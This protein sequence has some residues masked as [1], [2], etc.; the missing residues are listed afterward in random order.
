M[1]SDLRVKAAKAIGTSFVVFLLFT[2]S[3]YFFSFP[4]VINTS[5][6]ETQRTI[7]KLT[8]LKATYDMTD[9]NVNSAIAV[10]P[11]N[12]STPVDYAGGNIY[13]KMTVTSKPTD[14]VVVDQMCLYSS[15]FT[16]TTCSSPPNDPY[17]TT[18]TFYRKLPSMSTWWSAGGFDI[19]Q[20][21]DVIKLV[22][23]DASW[24]PYWYEQCGTQRYTGPLD[25]HQHM[26]YFYD[27]EAIMVASGA[28]LT[29]P[30]DWAD[31]PTTICGPGG[32]LPTVN[33][34]TV[35]T[36]PPSGTCPLKSTGDADCTG[37]TTVIDYTLWRLEYRAGCSITNQTPATCFDDR[38]GDG[39]LID[40]DFNGDGKASLLDFPRWKRG[41]AGQ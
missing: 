38:D 20:P 34:T 17:S 3:I 13:Y 22:H 7:F 29:R 12:W 2:A 18:G 11:A 31:C 19:N 5:A 24:Q 8:N 4:A 41:I 33:P 28:T 15:N 1:K 36:S 16:K 32:I 9:S 30:A 21:F 40:S 26:P 25:L 27:I 39:R 37:G 14:M 10:M 35:P 6:A 23:K